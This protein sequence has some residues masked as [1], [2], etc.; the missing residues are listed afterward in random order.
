[1]IWVKK[2]LGLAQEVDTGSSDI[3]AVILQVN[4]QHLVAISVYVP[5][6]LGPRGYTKLQSTT[7]EIRK[8]CK[9]QQEKHREKLDVLITGD[10]N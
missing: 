3:T 9:S 8:I 2:D 6:E 1:M 10:F 4:N 5:P 7:Q